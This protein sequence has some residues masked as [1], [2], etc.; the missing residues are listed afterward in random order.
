L[1]NRRDPN[2]PIIAYGG[3]FGEF[4]NDHYFIHKG[5]VFSDR[6]PKPHYPEMKKAYQWIGITVESADQGI[7]KIHN[8]FQ[9]I[10]LDDFAGSWSLS[11]NG[12]VISTGKLTLNKL[13]PGAEETVKV[14]FQLTN[15]KPGAEY[16]VRVS[17]V[18]S[19][20]KLWA[21]KGFEV[22]TEQFKVPVAVAESPNATTQG[23]ISMTQSGNEI[24]LKGSGFTV[25]FDKATGTF[26]SIKSGSTDLLA[27]RG[28]PRLH[29][30]RAPHQKDDMWA[31]KDWMKNGLNEIS[32][33]VVESSVN[34]TNPSTV[35]IAVKLKGEGKN[36]F[37]V[38]HDAVY[39]ISADGTIS[40]TNKFDSNNPKLIVGRIGV[41]FLLN[42]QL[43]QFVYFGRGPMENYSDRKRGFDVGLYES[44][45]VEQLT[46]YEKPMECGNHED[47]RWAKISQRGGAGIQVNSDKDLM[48]ISA[49]PYTDEELEKPE[50]KI[51][52]P[53]SSATVLCVSHQ[54]LGVGSNGCGPR[55]LDKYLVFAEPTSFAYSFKILA[56]K[57]R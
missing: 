5:T 43:D 18:Q 24:T 46:P 16:F 57:G 17:F 21:K 11:E 49:L 9:F 8:R 33:S 48:Q 3:G 36:S 37:S 34:Q 29:L 19:S 10:N 47:V 54:T 55:P 12:K 40:V 38:L 45:I 15:P 30:W 52:L 32:W 50:Y 23:S 7:L 6:S 35:Q 4:P 44:S 25:V 39:T 22:A 14:P 20:D 26:G 56:E 53:A 41:R 28:G 31:Y 42:K 2:H 13:A 1:W 27:G 51:D